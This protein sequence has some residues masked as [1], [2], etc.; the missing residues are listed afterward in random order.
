MK[1]RFFIVGIA[2]IVAVVVGLIG[3]LILGNNHD[4]KRLSSV[5]DPGQIYADAISKIESQSAA[6]SVTKTRQI[7]ADGALFTEQSRQEM[8]YQSYG[9]E[10]LTASTTETLSIGEHTTSIT[11]VFSEGIVYVTIDGSKFLGQST[12]E[13]Y[14][15]RLVPTAMLDVSLYGSIQGFDNGQAYLILFRQPNAAE[16]WV[17]ET[18]AKFIDAA[19]TV[20]ISHDGS[21][22]NSVYSTTYSRGGSII[23][24]SVSVTPAESESALEVPADK[25][26]YA[27]IAYWDGPR[28]LEQATGYLL[29]SETVSAFYDERVYCQAFGDERTRKISLYTAEAE[30]WA[31]RV[32]TQTQLLNTGHIGDVTRHLH[33]ELFID[34]KYTIRADGGVVTEN[35]QIDPKAMQAYCENL[36]V[37]TIMLPQDILNATCTDTGSTQRIE[38]AAN[39][40]FAQLISANACQTLYQKPELLNE[41]AEESNTETLICYV[42]LDKY[43]GLPLASGVEYIGSYRIEGL[44]YQLVFRADQNYEIPSLQAV[45]E[46]KE[47]AGQ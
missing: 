11:E 26:A 12:V 47:A 9:T 24:L 43:S 28:K 5:S 33:E 31:A 7:I 14:A 25:A 20:L 34:E 3:S 42:E 39:E 10:Q 16:G 37:S 22:L 45:N 21:I 46:I 41:L 40:A 17:A 19:A 2:C 44:P 23:H 35:D 27:P 29:Q 4:A 15:T 32:D 13:D 18:D 36:L 6:L 1:R 30:N 38:F 8:F